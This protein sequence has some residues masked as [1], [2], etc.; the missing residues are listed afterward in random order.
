MGREVPLLSFFHPDRAP[1]SSFFY[2]F[3]LPALLLP[4]FCHVYPLSN[5][6]SPLQPSFFFWCYPL[7]TLLFLPPSS[8]LSFYPLLPSY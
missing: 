1:L 8:S 7:S 4:S 6:S 2:L 3:P 5:P